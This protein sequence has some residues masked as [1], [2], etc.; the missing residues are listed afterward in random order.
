MQAN[1]PVVLVV[2]GLGVAG[3]LVWLAAAP[4]GDADPDAGAVGDEPAGAGAPVAQAPS[5]IAP[6][7]TAQI[8]ER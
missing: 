1:G 7:A 5:R 2:S 4:V 3:R 8:T 6:V